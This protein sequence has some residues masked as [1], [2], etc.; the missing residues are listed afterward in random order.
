MQQN[1]HSEINRAPCR[2]A[3]SPEMNIFSLNKPRCSS[4][5]NHWTLRDVRCRHVCFVFAPNVLFIFL[6]RSHTKRLLVVC[7]QFLVQYSCDKTFPWLPVTR[8][9]PTT[10]VCFVRFKRGCCLKWHKYG[11][12]HWLMWSSDTKMAHLPRV[13]GD[14]VIRIKSSVAFRLN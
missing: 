11:F 2:W 8:D 4:A 1:K 10:W 14:F 5:E 13:H 12:E 9:I 7:C 6:Q 3:D